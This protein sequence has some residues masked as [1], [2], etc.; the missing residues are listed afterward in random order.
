LN[1]VEGW[2]SQLERRA[3]YRSVF[4]SVNDLREA[5]H[6]F[7]KTYNEKLAKPFIWNK[8]ASAIIDSVQRAN[9]SI[10]ATTN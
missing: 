4:C 9:N 1:A 6:Q 8:K 10:I 7:I 2:F 5:I 3:L